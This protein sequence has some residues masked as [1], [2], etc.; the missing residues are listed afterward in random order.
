MPLTLIEKI[1][2]NPAITIIIIST[3]VVSATF[4]VVAW[5]YEQ[6]IEILDEAHELDINKIKDK[7]EEPN[8]EIEIKNKFLTEKQLEIESLERTIQIKNSEIASLNDKIK[9]PDAGISKM[10]D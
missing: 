3:I 8:R 9:K 1:K 10:H 6:R 7:L 2:N 4:K 5:H